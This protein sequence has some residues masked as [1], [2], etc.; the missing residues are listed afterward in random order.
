MICLTRHRICEKG[1]THG[2]LFFTCLLCIY[3]CLCVFPMH[4][5][6][7]SEYWN[8]IHKTQ[9]WMTWFSL[10]TSCDQIQHKVNTVNT[11]KKVRQGFAFQFSNFINMKNKYHILH[12][13]NSETVNHISVPPPLNCHFFLPSSLLSFLPLILNFKISF[14]HLQA[15]KVTI[16]LNKYKVK[17]ALPLRC[18]N[19]GLKTTIKSYDVSLIPTLFSLSMNYHGSG[20][21]WNVSFID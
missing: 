21:I 12:R 6:L 13:C 3:F 5:A 8:R 1:V 19:K 17:T 11:T 7:F 16:L 9:E 15:H 20:K 14:C 18:I 4:N 10:D 2:H